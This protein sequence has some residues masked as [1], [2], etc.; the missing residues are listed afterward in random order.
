[1]LDFKTG[2]APSPKQINSGFSPQLTLT[3]AILTSGG[4]EGLKAY[5]GDLTYLKVTGRKPPGEVLVR[6]AAG[7]ESEDAAGKAYEGVLKLLTLYQDP[8]RGYLSRTAPQFVKTWAGDY[9]HL[10]RVF[11]WSTG[12]EGEGDE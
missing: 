11:E 7:P 6:K 12:S 1:V 8:A 5:A 10:A 9:D 4:F 3:M 2:G